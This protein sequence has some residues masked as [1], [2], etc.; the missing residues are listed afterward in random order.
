VL[1]DALRLAHAIR[2]A[3][4]SAREWHVNGGLT[5]CVEMSSTEFAITLAQ[6]G[7]SAT[8]SGAVLAWPASSSLHEQGDDTG[9]KQRE[10]NEMPAG[11]VRCLGESGSRGLVAA[12]HPGDHS[13]TC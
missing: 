10:G 12:H 4:G 11:C 3:R 5:A 7:S 2:L 13:V 6:Y 1:F 9:P 8:S